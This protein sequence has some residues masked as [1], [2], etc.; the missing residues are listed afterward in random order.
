MLANNI[1]KLKL[2]YADLKSINNNAFGLNEDNLIDQKIQDKKQITAALRDFLLNPP[3]ANTNEG[4]EF[5]SIKLQD[6]YW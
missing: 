5:M 1:S 4:H 3:D 2:L 6:P